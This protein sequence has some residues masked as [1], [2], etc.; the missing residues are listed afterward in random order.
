MFLSLIKVAC[1]NLFVKGIDLQSMANL[2]AEDANQHLMQ[3]EF[4]KILV[5]TDITSP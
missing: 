5:N 4:V 2:Q 3:D 1:V